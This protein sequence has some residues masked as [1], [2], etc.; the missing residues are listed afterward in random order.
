[1]KFTSMSDCE[2][3]L[4][5]MG[6]TDFSPG[7]RRFA[8]FYTRSVARSSRCCQI[9]SNNNQRFSE[10]ETLNLLHTSASGLRPLNQ[11]LP[12]KQNMTRRLL[13]FVAAITLLLI[14][15]L[16]AFADPVVML[17]PGSSVTFNYAGLLPSNIGPFNFNAQATY[18]INASGTQVTVDFM[19]NPT[20]EVLLKGIESN[21]TPTFPAFSFAFTGLPSGV[22]WTV[23]STTLSGT[24]SGD[25]PYNFAI[26]TSSGLL[27]PG[28]S[29]RVV[30]TFNTPIQGFTFD[31]L[32]N[33]NKTVSVFV[34]PDGRPFGG[35]GVD[36]SIPEP[37]TLVLLGTGLAATAAGIRKRR[38]SPQPE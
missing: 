2:N 24:G 17:T 9:I 32:F 28:E 8:L 30:L 37:A 20:S 35:V 31:Q 18:S 22:A 3:H 36:A 4:R 10:P 34:L 26:L 29:G 7:F 5:Q 19:N 11:P 27:K 1:M 23:G 38:R 15:N 13:W 33:F 12:R 16:S 14:L 6:G 21:I 25:G